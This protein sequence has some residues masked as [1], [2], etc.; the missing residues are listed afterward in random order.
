MVPGVGYGGELKWREQ[1]KAGK[2]QNPEKSLEFSTLAVLRPIFKMFS[3]PK[4]SL[5]KAK[6]HLPSPPPKS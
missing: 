4:K 2:S 3:I 5:H 1:S 6:H